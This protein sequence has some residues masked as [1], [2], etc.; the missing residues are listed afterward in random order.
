MDIDIDFADKE[1]ILELIDHIPAMQ[2]SGD[3]EQRHISGVYVT[4]IPDNPLT[5]LAAIDYEE[6]E[7]RGYF[8]ID[9]LNMSLYD[10]I[11]SE[12][13]LEVLLKEEPQWARLLDKSFCDRLVHLNGHYDIVRKMK[14]ESIEQLAMVLAMIRP[15]K[16]H[17]IGKPWEEIRKEVWVKPTDGSYYFKHSHS[18][19][20]AH[21]VVLHMNLICL[22]ED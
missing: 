10:A 4:G 8:K 5:G 19:A 17:L 16:R 6:A 13:E 21:L 9:F 14:P 20:Y 7:K 3:D 2:K 15:A 1:K 12:E 18:I 11:Q 22:T